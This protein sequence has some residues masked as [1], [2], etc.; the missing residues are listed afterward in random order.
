MIVCRPLED[1]DRAKWDQFVRSH[2]GGS[3]FHLTAW[4]DTIYDIFAYRPAYRIAIDNGEVV[5]VLPLFL[6]DNFMLGKVLI[7]TP[8]AVYG[9]ILARHRRAH[10]ALCE[11]LQALARQE[12]VQYAEL[13]NISTQQTSGFAGINRYATFTRDVRPGTAEDLLHALPQ[14]TRN[15]VRKALKTPFSMRR[16]PDQDAFYRLL[17][18]T[19]R[20]H[21]TPVFPPRFFAAIAENF[22]QDVDVREVVLDGQVVA[23]SMNLFFRDQMHTYYAASTRDC[24]K[25][26]PNDYMYFQHLLWAG[27]NGYQVFDFGR[28]KV[29]TGSYEFKKHWATSQPLPYEVMLVRRSEVPNFSPANPKFHVAM[30]LWQ[31]M[32]LGLTRVIGPALV[33]LF[34]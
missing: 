2:P 21:G 11:S 12:D 19:Y 3:P 7:S 29:G 24:W 10:D 27:C 32:P 15:V 13:R 31:R 20:R 8:F 18:E 9:G 28:S 17:L 26:G 33:A 14:K 4:H 22:G 25:L 34:P 5:G 1:R 30:R 23:A 16:A 6:V